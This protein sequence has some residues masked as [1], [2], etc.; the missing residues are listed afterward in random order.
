MSLLDEI[1]KE[2]PTKRAFAEAI[3][4]KAHQVYQWREVPPGRVA[5][6]ERFLELIR[7]NKRMADQ[8]GS[9]RR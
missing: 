6:V 8:L 9:C 1:N 2:F 4:M 5:Q 3:G 7:E